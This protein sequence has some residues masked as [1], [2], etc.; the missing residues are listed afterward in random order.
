M[1]FDRKAGKDSQKCGGGKYEGPAFTIAALTCATKA[2]ITSGG[3]FHP[4]NGWL[5][6]VADRRLDQVTGGPKPRDKGRLGRSSDLTGRNA[7]EL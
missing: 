3:R 4:E 7:S 5:A 2:R 1:E 6:P